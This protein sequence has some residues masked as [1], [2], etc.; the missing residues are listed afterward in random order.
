LRRRPQIGQIAV[1]SKNGE[2]DVDAIVD[3]DGDGD[4]AV[5]GPKEVRRCWAGLKSRRG[6]TARDSMV[7]R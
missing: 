5:G 4:V 6:A 7:D 2:V 3:G 1:P